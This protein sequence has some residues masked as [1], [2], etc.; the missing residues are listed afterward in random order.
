MQREGLEEGVTLGYKLITT[1]VS[2][3]GVIIEALLILIDY[4]LDK[5][6]RELFINLTQELKR[7]SGNDF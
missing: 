3:E 5:N 4:A 1:R 6:D 2:G 7:I